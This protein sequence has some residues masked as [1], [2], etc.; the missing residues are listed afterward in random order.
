MQMCNIA[1]HS[2]IQY[3]S[4]NVQRCIAKNYVEHTHSNTLAFVPMH[5]NAQIK[6]KEIQCT[7]SNAEYSAKKHDIHALVAMHQPSA[8]KPQL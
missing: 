3:K 8:T 7:A 6:I 2:S 4:T 5:M 1:Q